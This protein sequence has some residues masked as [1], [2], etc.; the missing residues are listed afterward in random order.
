MLEVTVSVKGGNEVST[1][2]D[3]STGVLGIPS[4]TSFTCTAFTGVSSAILNLVTSSNA[5]RRCDATRYAWIC[6]VM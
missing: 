2:T 5:I 6:L 1:D 3:R 4:S